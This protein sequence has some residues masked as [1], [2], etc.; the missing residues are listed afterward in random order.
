MAFADEYRRA[1]KHKWRH[2]YLSYRFIQQ[3]IPKVQAPGQ[4]HRLRRRGID[5][6]KL[7]DHMLNDLKRVNEFYIQK[8]RYLRLRFRQVM[9]N[10]H[11]L[12]A[13]PSSL[14]ARGDG[15]L[16][17]ALLPSKL[18]C[19]RSID[20]F[21]RELQDL[22]QYCLL[23]LEGFQRIFKRYRKHVEKVGSPELTAVFRTFETKW[24]VCC[25]S[26]AF[27]LL[28]SAVFL[29]SECLSPVVFALFRNSALWSESF[30]IAPQSNGSLAQMLSVMTSEAARLDFVKPP[31][32]GALSSP[33]SAVIRPVPPLSSSE[34]RALSDLLLALEASEQLT[35]AQLRTQAQDPDRL[36]RFAVATED[37]A[38]MRALLPRVTNVDTPDDDG[39]SPLQV[40][41]GMPLAFCMSVCG[42]G[43]R[44]LHPLCGG[45]C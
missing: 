18:I 25:R 45:V 42:V 16:L 33:G 26:S 41:A 30:S 10:L 28:W 44:V 6:E 32:P 35:A 11:R 36:L 2:R 12:Y 43:R 3:L 4:R 37:L 8:D 39:L 9:S 14:T 40:A 29:V 22:R 15:S 20:W 7:H 17:T 1:L 27:D 31:S 38:A 5:A 21:T 13:L 24:Y 23:N 34:Q 19:R